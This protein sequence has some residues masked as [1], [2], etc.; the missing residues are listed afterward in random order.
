MEGPTHI[1][2]YHAKLYYLDQLP[3]KGNKI[4]DLDNDFERYLNKKRKEQL[5]SDRQEAL[6]DDRQTTRNTGTTTGGRGTT[7]E[8]GTST[9]RGNTSTSSTGGGGG[10]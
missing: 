10:Y 5:L 2:A 1:K 3:S 8:R 9:S 7:G 4:S 6:K